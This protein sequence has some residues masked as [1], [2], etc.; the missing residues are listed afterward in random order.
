[1]TKRLRFKVDLQEAL[2]R[3]EDGEILEKEVPV[4]NEATR[5]KKITKADVKLIVLKKM[6]QV[7]DELDGQF[8]AIR[9]EGRGL[10]GAVDENADRE[11]G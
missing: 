2:L 10:Q 9:A 7:R 1:M 3:K 5:E 11:C 4:D 8:K 6:A